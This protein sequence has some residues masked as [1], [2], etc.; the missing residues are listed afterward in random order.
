M[1]RYIGLILILLSTLSMAEE[2]KGKGFFL[3][4]DLERINVEGTYSSKLYNFENDESYTRPAF[5]VGYQYYFT[6]VYFKYSQLQEDYVPYDVDSDSYEA[7]V[8]YIP[9]LYRADSYAIRLMV[10]ASIG[11]TD[12]EMKDLDPS[13]IGNVHEALGLNDYSQKKAI[14]GFQLGVMMELSVGLSAELGYRYR[15]G[16]LLEFDDD[17]GDITVET[18]RKQYYMGLNYMF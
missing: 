15:E 14:Y 17:S 1:R 6:R 11:Y 16:N 4:V 18:K 7:N 12:N 13:S 2:L 5:K 10:G 9:I 3:G 8:E